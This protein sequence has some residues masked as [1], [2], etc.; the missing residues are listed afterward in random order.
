MSNHKP[1]NAATRLAERIAQLSPERRG[2]LEPE[3][4]AT[5]LD[6][7]DVVARALRERGITH[8]YGVAGRPSEV[9]LS[10]CFGQGI[11]PIGVYH[12]SSAVCMAVAHNFQSGRLAAVALV[13]AGPAA[14]NALTG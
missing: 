2:L 10:A 1:E 8:V 13:S 5:P 6:G 14:T 9:I 3:R 4:A 11:R 7:T 12:Q